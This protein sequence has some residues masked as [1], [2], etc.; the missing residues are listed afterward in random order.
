M[1]LSI[2]RLLWP[3]HSIKY[4]FLAILSYIT[5]HVW[6]A[7]GNISGNKMKINKFKG[8]Y[9]PTVNATKRVENPVFQLLKASSLKSI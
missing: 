2:I 9:P 1:S 5:G 7:Y 6:N 8:L 4:F 3:N